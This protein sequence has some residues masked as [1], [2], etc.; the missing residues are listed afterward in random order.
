MASKI[1]YLMK[2][3][4]LLN[5]LLVSLLTASIFTV[6]EAVKDALVFVN[7]AIAIALLAINGLR[8]KI[9]EKKSVEIVTYLI[10]VSEDE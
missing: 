10:R 2:A 5:F 7:L 4:K 6:S 9:A 3:E 8:H 1:N